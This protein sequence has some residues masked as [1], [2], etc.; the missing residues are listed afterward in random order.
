MEFCF[1]G[2]TL[3]IPQQFIHI[4]NAMAKRETEAE[5]KRK[6]TLQRV[7]LAFHKKELAKAEAALSWFEEK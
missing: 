2:R 3:K 1:Q 4:R 5:A 6:A 7:E